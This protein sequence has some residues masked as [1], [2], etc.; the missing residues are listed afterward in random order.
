MNSE[1][2]PDEPLD[3]ICRLVSIGELD[4]PIT[5]TPRSWLGANG[6]GVNIASPECSV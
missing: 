2:I 3:E 6:E 1:K 4:E 5:A